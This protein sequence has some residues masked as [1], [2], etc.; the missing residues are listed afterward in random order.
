MLELAGIVV[1]GAVLAAVAWTAARRR[2]S[3][4]PT[5]NRRT[6]HNSVRNEVT[7]P[8][9]GT[10]VQADKI[11]GPVIIG[12]VPVASGRLAETA[13]QLAYAVAARWRIE[14]D[15]RQVQ[16]PIPL[17]IRWRAHETLADHPLNIARRRADEPGDPVDVSGD[18]DRITDVFHGIP[19][20]R[21]VVLG[22][23]GAGK[24][25]LAMR[26][27]LDLLGSR[28]PG[29]PVPVIFGLGSWDPAIPL[30]DW[31]VAQL[32]RDHP[33][34]AE[35]GADNQTLAAELVDARWILPVLDGFDEIADGLHHTALRQ[36]STTGPLLLTSRTDEY[37]TA[38]ARTR[39]LPLA[40]VVELTDL[41]LDDV[42]D[43]LPRTS[44]RLVRASGGACSTVTTVWDVVLDQ[45]HAE[46]ETTAAAQLTRVLTTPLMVA[47]ARTVYS[48]R[49]DR[50]PVELLDSTRFATPDSIEDH[51]LESFLPTVYRMR[52]GRSRAVRLRRYDPEHARRWLSYLAEHMDRLGTRSL[53]WWELGTAMRRSSRTVL[54]TFLSGLAFGVTTGVGN[55]PVDLVGAALPLGFAIRRGLVVGAMHGLVIGLMFG[56][57]YWFA[58][59]GGG[60]E[61]SLVR[62]RLLGG[63]HQPRATFAAR[64]R[65]GVLGG[66]ATGTTIVLIDRVLVPPLGLDD[67]LGGGLLQSAIFPVLVGLG[68]GVVFVL[69]TWLEVPID[70]RSAVS[71]ANLLASNRTNALFMLLVWALV[72]GLAG[73]LVT[74]FTAGPLR[75]FEEGAAFGLEA[76]FGGGLSYGLSLTAWGQWVV[77]A[78]M[79]LP[80][81]GRLPWRLV[82][83]LDDACRRGALRQAGALY[84]FRHARLQK[85][86]T[87]RTG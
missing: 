50:S 62:M 80:A 31:L 44:P 61:P 75:S 47:L 17:P 58:E 15:R 2:G 29:D 36:L 42:T 60:Q 7:A 87:D 38:V 22:R 39:G 82:A 10:V 86:L 1:V 51:L 71:P 30:E 8:V 85:Q 37:A 27:V 25:V 33:G 23:A 16:D 3:S 65:W 68:T 40:A 5:G 66:F 14:E 26:F 81:T 69:V 11:E 45:L 77:L 32:I 35:L 48:D 34:L 41:T 55:I 18:L 59:G 4:T 9:S 57:L 67:G 73:W 64:L 79:W 43:Y 72:F 70:V 63:P 19:S 76:A 24:T 6:A 28:V 12:Q 83:F 21:L 56:V 49:G 54:V 46:P 84:Q 74:A 13:D 20:R 52:P 53:A 78:R